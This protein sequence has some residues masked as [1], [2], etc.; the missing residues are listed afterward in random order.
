M[1]TVK[2]LLG[3]LSRSVHDEVLGRLYGLDGRQESVERARLRAMG[4][5]RGLMEV[6]SPAEGAPAALFSGPGRT[7]LGGN[8]TDHQEGRVLCASVDL[9]MIACAAPNGL[10]IIRI[11][12]EGYSPVEIDLD[13]LNPREEERNTS[14]ALVRGVASRVAAL[15]YPPVGFD[16]YVSS[17]VPAGSGLSSSAA[18]EVL[19]GNIF[20]HFCC[21]RR[22]DP[23]AI[24]R[25]G[26]YAENVYFGKPSGLMDQMG[27]SV[28]GAVAVDFS[29][30]TS[31]IV[32]RLNY[33]FSLSGHTLCIIDTGSSHAD[34]TDHYASIPKEMGEV[35]ACFG[36][37]V[38]REVPREDFLSSIPT[39][40]ERCGDRAVLRAKH[41]YEE[42]QRAD[43][44]RQ[45]LAGGDFTRFLR[46]VNRSGLSS[47]I[48]L[49][50]VWGG[51]DP[52]QQAVSIALALGRELL[53]ETGAI[54]VHGG[55]FAGTIQA[56]VPKDRL[57]SFR[58]GMERVLGAGSCHVL[59]IR[60]KGGCTFI[61]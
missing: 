36:K 19:L 44:E 16:A 60:P 43:E 9:D 38:L 29:N 32:E 4:V 28:G 14:L 54:R 3:E 37:R 35:A 41:F 26:Q 20:N 45:A 40:R 50:N 1:A 34:L 31:P 59:H 10:G 42:N 46:L 22:L 30:P 6:F 61:C 47:E 51:T 13:S 52:R 11:W 33:D 27:S 5:V 58:R 39:L 18:Y 56:F 48:Q 17:A 21:G 8:H 57:D 55:G 25:I 15:G 2:Q 23:V 49:Q 12:S 53:E 7:E 24:A